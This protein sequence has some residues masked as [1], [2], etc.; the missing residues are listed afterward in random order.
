MPYFLLIL[1]REANSDS[2]VQSP[3]SAEDPNHSEPE[4]DIMLLKPRSDYYAEQ[5]PTPE[6]VFLLIE[7]AESSLVLDREIKLPLY[8]QAGVPEVWIV[9]IADQQIEVHRSLTAEKYQRNAGGK[10][11]ANHYR[12]FLFT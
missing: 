7:V 2:S 1:A 6:D 12:S 3:L 9:N 4:P 11:G 8:A 5:H 10:T